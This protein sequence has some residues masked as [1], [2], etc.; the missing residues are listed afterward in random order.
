[1]QEKIEEIV[2]KEEPD[3]LKCTK[4]SGFVETGGF[5]ERTTIVS[6][7]KTD[8][9]DLQSPNKVKVK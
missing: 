7:D 9:R 1:V 4:L 8:E 3:Y 5:A 6:Q 2:R